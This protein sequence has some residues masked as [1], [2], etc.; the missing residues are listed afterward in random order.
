LL[1]WSLVRTIN[2]LNTFSE[3]MPA[4]ADGKSEE[5]DKPEDLAALVKAKDGKALRQRKK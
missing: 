2:V 1:P 3:S 4:D 5:S